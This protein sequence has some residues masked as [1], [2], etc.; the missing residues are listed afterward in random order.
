M[1]DVLRR[2]RITL[3]YHIDIAEGWANN[4]RLYEATGAGAMLLTDRR[5]NI[6][7]IY[8]DGDEV[9][10][11][12]STRECIDQTKRYLADE[13]ARAAIAAGGQRKA[14]EVNNYF[15]RTGEILEHIAELS[16]AQVLS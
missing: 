15:N 9:A 5:R 12:G 8:V 1:Y 2:S 7:D 16:N 14:V 13:P 4:M 6:G 11:Y 10:T 3:N